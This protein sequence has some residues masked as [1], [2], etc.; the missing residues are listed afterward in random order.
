MGIRLGR[1][2]NCPFMGVFIPI[3]KSL[4]WGFKNADESA[5]YNALDILFSNQVI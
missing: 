2:K 3:P 5:N 4:V 1:I